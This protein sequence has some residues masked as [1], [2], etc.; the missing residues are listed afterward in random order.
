MTVSIHDFAQQTSLLGHPAF[1]ASVL[2]SSP[3]PLICHHDHLQSPAMKMLQNNPNCQDL[4]T[5][6]EGHMTFADSSHADAGEGRSTAC[7]LQICQGGVISHASWVPEP[8]AMA[9]AES[10]N[11]CHSAA[12]MKGKCISSV[13]NFIRNGCDC[14]QPHRLL[15]A[16][17]ICVD[18]NAAI[19]MNQSE[20]IA[21]RVRH[22]ESRFWHGRQATQAGKAK[23]IEVDGKTEQPTDIGAKNMQEKKDARKHLDLFEAP[24]CT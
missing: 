1:T 2:L 11:N 18:D 17:P 22:V 7:Q 12:I 14:Q 8:V 10:E 19:I 24:F 3:K 23:F 13:L 20:N 9:Q 4:L 16:I 5:I 6:C 15:S 21:Q